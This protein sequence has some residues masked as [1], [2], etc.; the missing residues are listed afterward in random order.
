MTSLLSKDLNVSSLK[1][2]LWETTSA[3]PVG[4]YR[5]YYTKRAHIGTPK[6]DFSARPS[7]DNGLYS[8]FFTVCTK[9]DD[10]N[11][12]DSVYASRDLIRNTLCREIAF[13]YTRGSGFE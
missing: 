13:E 9:V 2:C 5:K 10:R 1:N 3:R 12:D 4:L 6:K 11:E 8:M 7:V